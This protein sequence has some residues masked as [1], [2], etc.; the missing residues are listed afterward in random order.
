MNQFKQYCTWHVK[1]IRNLSYELDGRDLE[2][3][4]GGTELLI[5]EVPVDADLA[6]FVLND[7]TFLT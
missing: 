6:K 2:D 1:N 5:D 7:C 3:L 4:L